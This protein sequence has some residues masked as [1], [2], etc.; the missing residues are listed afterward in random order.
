MLSHS[1][2][3]LQ[4]YEFK[5]QTDGRTDTNTWRENVTKRDMCT[6]GTP[7]AS[8]LADVKDASGGRQTQ[9]VTETDRRLSCRR[10]LPSGSLGVNQRELR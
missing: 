5:V 3:K 1:V 4:L 8:N 2:G 6:M 7:V 10:K 9:A